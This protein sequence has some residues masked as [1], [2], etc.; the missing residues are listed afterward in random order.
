MD[1]RPESEN[2][3]TVKVR[4][5]HLRDGRRN[6]S[7]FGR[8]DIAPSAIARFH[9]KYQKTPSCWLWTASKY[10]HGYGQIAI[11][12]RNGEQRATYAHRVAYVLAHGDIPQGAVVMHS[13]DV[14]A[15]V[16]PAHLMLGDQATNVADA[17]AKGHYGGHA[18]PDL[19]KLSVD[20][21]HEIRQSTETLARLAARYG[22]SKSCICHIRSGRSR[23]AA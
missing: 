3:W 14:R 20:Q 2:T 8:A 13:C 1:N 9:T 22:V 19:W 16:N 11:G 21:V 5:T 12:R 7:A 4:S 10:R 17:K 15:C 23:K 18:R 6:K